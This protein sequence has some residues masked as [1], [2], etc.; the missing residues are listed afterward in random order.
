[1]LD[2]YFKL[3]GAHQAL[4]SL[5]LSEMEKTAVWGTLARIGSKALI[6]PISWA[7][8]KSVGTIAKPLASVGQRILGQIGQIN[9]RAAQFLQQAGRGAAREAAGGGLLMG[10]LNAATAEPGD[11]LSAFGRGFAGGA[12]GGA[13][14]GMG[15]NVTRMGLGRALGAKNMANLYRAGRPGIVGGFR[16]PQGTLGR[17]L[18]SIGAKTITGGVP[19]ASGIGLSMLAP[20]FEGR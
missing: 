14:F 6:K 19:L 13:A 9:P 11:R 2:N 12:L 10:T 4:N 1:M 7:G 16:G 5:G 17:G 18:R 20:T 15:R 3:A 8:Q